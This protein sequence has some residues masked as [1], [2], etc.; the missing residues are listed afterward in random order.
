MKKIYF[1]ILILFIVASFI[2]I[3]VTI[4]AGNNSEDYSGE[5]DGDDDKNIESS[6]SFLP[7]IARRNSHITDLGLEEINLD[8]FAGYFSSKNCFRH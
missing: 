2:S 6:R 3:L 8:Y 4:Q 5:D 1:I 7:D